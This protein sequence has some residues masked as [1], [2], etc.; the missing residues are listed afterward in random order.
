MAYSK[1]KQNEAAAKHFELV[2]EFM[3]KDQTV[4]L[5]KRVQVHN[6]LGLLRARQKKFDL[7]IVQF[8]ET[9]KLDPKQPGILNALALA[10]LVHPNQALRN[11]SKALE[12]AKKACALTQS[13]HPLY[14]NTLAIAYA[15]LNN[16]S[17]AIKT[18]ERALALAQAKDDQTLVI[19][20]QKQLDLSK[21]A[22]ADSKQEP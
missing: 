2:L 22:L 10:L 4:S 15:A 19:N 18:S 3:P 9:L 11:P 6:E 14:L 5:A 13:K 16:F 17:E 7:A 8:E 1:S 21:R 20:L 12:L